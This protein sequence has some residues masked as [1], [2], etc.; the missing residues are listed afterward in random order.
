MTKY[1]DHMQD[2]NEETY[3]ELTGSLNDKK[4]KLNCPSRINID[5]KR[6]VLIGYF[7]MNF[8]NLLFNWQFYTKLFNNCY[9]I[10]QESNLSAILYLKLLQI[11]LLL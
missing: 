7:S 10:I 2:Q 11:S 8:K 3:K 5:T 6:R 9:E 1:L 4:T